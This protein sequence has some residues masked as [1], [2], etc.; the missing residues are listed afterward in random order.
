MT[1][2]VRSS[3]GF[4]SPQ[5]RVEGYDWN[6]IAADL[7]SFGCAVLQELLTPSECQDLASLYPDDKHFRSYIHMARHG[8]GQANTSI[9]AIRCRPSSPNYARRF[10][11]T[12]RR[13]P[14]RGT[15]E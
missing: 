3:A 14:M 11:R 4:K 6:G 8:F 7:D 1:A 5:R 9:S 13:R 15:N 10:I 12:W 2:V